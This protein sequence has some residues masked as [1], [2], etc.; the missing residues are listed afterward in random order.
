MKQPLTPIQEKGRRV[1]VHIQEKVGE[2]IKRLIKEGHIIKLT[3]STSEFFVAPVVI[4]AKNDSSV[5]NSNGR[6]AHDCS[7]FKKTNIK[8]QIF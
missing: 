5:K 6:K 1:P 7:D 4:T 2:E 8:Y 3:K